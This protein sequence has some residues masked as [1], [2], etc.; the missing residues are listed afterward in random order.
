MSSPSEKMFPGL[1]RRIH[2]TFFTHEES[3]FGSTEN[4]APTLD[5]L[6]MDK[7]GW[8]PKDIPSLPAPGASGEN[9]SESKT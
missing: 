3:L 4:F 8:Y 2:L 1:S 9:K 6:A 5:A 7:L